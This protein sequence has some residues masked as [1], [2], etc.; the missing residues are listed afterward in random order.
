[1]N[2]YF[3]FLTGAVCCLLIACTKDVETAAVENSY[4]IKEYYPTTKEEVTPM[5]KN[6]LRH[7]E[8][9]NEQVAKTDLG[10][11]PDTDPNEAMWLMEGASNY[12]SEYDGKRFE[13]MEAT[14]YAISVENVLD[15]DGLKMKGTD[16]VNKFDDFHT[17][18][19]TDFV[20]KPSIIDYQIV[21]VSD[22]LTM[23][24]AS[25]IHSKPRTGPGCNTYQ[26]FI[27]TIEGVL[28]QT[29]DNGS[30]LNSALNLYNSECDES[31]ACPVFYTNIDLLVSDVLFSEFAE[32]DE[33]IN[34]Q[35]NPITHPDGNPNNY[36]Y[37]TP[38]RIPMPSSEFDFWAERAIELPIHL[39]E[40]THGQSLQDVEVHILY[41]FI[42]CTSGSPSN[43][44]V[45]SAQEIVTARGSNR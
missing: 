23:I 7:T 17:L 24:E 2:K 8:S 35:N 19:E 21:S 11:F 32:Y 3:L 12:L 13:E 29:I 18:V 43:P 44:V 28:N 40:Y 4:E 45:Y 31:G 22:E 5:V 41:Y 10:D 9:Y 38:T 26:E 30:S 36:M 6:F 39:W 37:Y 14:F 16:M 15:A 20:E 25:V 1:M 34:A 33:K 27:A 42:G